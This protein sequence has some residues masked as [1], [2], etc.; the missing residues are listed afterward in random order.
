MFEGYGKFVTLIESNDSEELQR[1][2]AVPSQAANSA[3]FQELL[4]KLQSNTGRGE[5]T[6]KL[7]DRG[8]K[9][10]TACYKF[11]N[12]QDF[13]QTKQRPFLEKLK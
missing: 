11:F 3:P 7:Y 12:L 10:F 13:H 8:N 5:K 4:E 6:D 2:F 1:L 9:L